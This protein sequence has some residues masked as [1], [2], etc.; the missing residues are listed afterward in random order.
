MGYNMNM[1]DEKKPS[2]KVLLPEGWRRFRIIGCEEKTSKAGNL[3][4]VITAQDDETL[5]DDTWYAIAEPKKRWFLKT[6][7][8]ACDCKAS[9]DGVYDWEIKDVLGK[10]VEGLVV[11]EDNEWINRQGETIKSEQHKI[12]DIRAAAERAKEPVKTEE[13]KGWDE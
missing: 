7:L 13:E 3:M 12:V 8:A 6:L 10:E 1:N 11:H 4:F 2:T 9:D 5:Y